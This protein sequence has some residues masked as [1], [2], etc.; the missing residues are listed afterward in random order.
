MDLK[1]KLTNPAL[2]LV[3]FEQ[4]PPAEDNPDALQSTLVELAKVRPLVDGINIP[5]IRDEGRQGDRTYKFIPRVE[6]RVLAKHIRAESEAHIII[7]RVVVHEPDQLAWFRRTREEFGITEVV[8]VGGES[9]AVS[10]PGPG[11]GEVARQVLAAGLPFS[12]GGISI[13]SRNNEAERVRRK[14]GA[15]L[16]FFTTQVL[17]DSNDVVWMLQRLN[18]LRARIFLSFCPVSHPGDLKFLRWLGADVPKDLDRFLLQSRDGK[19]TPAETFFE[20]SLSLAQRILMD[21]FDHLPPDPPAIGLNIE[22]INRRNY[23]G[24]IKMLESLGALYTQLLAR[25]FQATSAGSASSG[26]L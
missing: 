20:R 22:H 5:E 17:F 26:A 2:P 3:F 15:G 9:S 14:H 13:P 10:Y 8:V 11:V 24:A 23:G 21:V 19:P 12:L 7:N 25:R 18:G 4:V 16:T 6:P 1:S